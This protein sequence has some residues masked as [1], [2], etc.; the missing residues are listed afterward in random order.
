[1]VN[2]GV[3]GTY[4]NLD[5]FGRVVDHTW[6][7]KTAGTDKDRFSY[8]YDA[9][10]NR[11]WRKNEVATAFSE[12]YHSNG[13]A[14]NA[15]YDGLD[16]MIDFRRGTL[17][18]SGGRSNDQ[19]TA[20]V[21]RVEDFTLDQVGNWT[22]FKHDANGVGW[23]LEQTR[24]HNDVNE[25]SSIGETAGDAWVDPAYDAAGNMTEGPR[26]SSPN[27]TPGGGKNVSEEYRLF[28]VYD[29]WNRLVTVYEDTDDDGTLDTSGTWDEVLGEYRYDG[30]NRR[31]VKLVPTAFDGETN[32]PTTYKRTDYYYSSRWQVLQECF[33]GSVA[34]ESKDST[35]ATA[36]KAEYVWGAR[37]MDAP[38]VRWYDYDDDDNFT[39]T[40][41][42]LYYTQDANFNVTSLV[43]TSGAVR[44]RYVYDSYG[45]VTIY[46]SDWSSTVAWGDSLKNEILYCGY[47]WD[48]ETGLYQVRYRYH[49][50]TLG[51]WM[52][53]DPLGYVDDL[54]LYVY[55]GGNPALFVDPS[56][57]VTVLQ[58]YNALATSYLNQADAL[59]LEISA[60]GGSATQRPNGWA[61]AKWKRYGKKIKS[62]R[63]KGKGIRRK[64]KEVQE[65]LD[66]IKNK[67]KAKQKCSVVASNETGNI[68]RP[69]ELLNKH[70]KCAIVIYL[71]HVG[72]TVKAKD[73]NGEEIWVY[74][75]VYDNADRL[76]GMSEVSEEEKRRRMARGQW[77]YP[78]ASGAGALTCFPGETID[79][80]RQLGYNWLKYK[81]QF[82]DRAEKKIKALDHAVSLVKNQVSK[83]TKELCES[84]C[85]DKKVKVFFVWGDTWD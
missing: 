49:H 27:H 48:P 46:N 66:A 75:R 55:V 54:H 13:A 57:L 83:Y 63:K 16:R 23:D 67:M 41:E 79:L 64:I 59:K 30:L 82:D 69:G 33:A 35:V 4:E 61:K 39:D 72:G 20:D 17:S 58:G 12:L 73:E 3:A 19:I 32:E 15:A 7:I 5:R 10:G 76:P 78:G 81:G 28:H 40:D 24:G 11:L 31:I 56:G 26:P 42:V 70:P 8:G 6:K 53:R 34:A 71:G 2:T 85:C 37:Y 25:I 9:S 74:H 45:K 62:L 80:A 68:L 77:P 36:R 50:P 65:Q 47:R 44:E 51:R 22:A 52:Q 84:E 43:N 60:A 18:T 14:L 1:L 29:A 38:V 21:K